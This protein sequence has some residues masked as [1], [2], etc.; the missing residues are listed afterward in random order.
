MPDADAASLTPGE[1]NYWQSAEGTEKEAYIEE[2]IPPG[3]QV[4]VSPLDGPVYADEHGL[5][6]YKW[7]LIPLRNGSLGDR[8]DGPSNC[9]DEVLRV[10]VG[11]M[12][13]YPAGLILPYADQGVTCAQVWPPALAPEDAEEVGKWTLVERKNG[14]KQWAYDGFPLYTS[15]LD[16]KP[17]DVLGGTKIQSGVD[18]GVVR[19]P[20]R[21]RADV[22]P[23][24]KVL[25]STT[26]G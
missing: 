10:E 16:K 13:P 24:F 20:V 18:S 22:A 7:P 8:E 9:T 1:T 14:A 25:S 2:L 12:S 4:V 15:N 19:V 23:G 26:R 6:L 11:F 17:G 5:T 21:P 3:V